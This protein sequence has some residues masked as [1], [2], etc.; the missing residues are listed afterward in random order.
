VQR[1]SLRH[2]PA[3]SLARGAVFAG[4]ALVVAA[5]TAAP[6]GAVGVPQRILAGPEDQLLASENATYVI[7]TQSSELSPNRYHAYERVRATNQVFR[8]NPRGT[9]GYAGGI[10]PDQDRA[11]YQQIDGQASDLFTIDLGTLRRIKLPVPI[12]TGRWEWG[13]R[14]S[15]S[16]FLFAR[17]APLKTTMFLYDRAA[18]TMERLVS[19]DLTKYYVAPGAVGERYATWSVCGPRTCNAFI[20]DTDTDQTK[21]IPAPDGKP[22]YAPIVDEAEGLV[23]FVRSGPTC[24][25][26]VRIMRLALADLAAAPVGLLTL[27]VGVDVGGQMSLEHVGARVDL[28]FSRYRCAPQQGD[29]YR[30]KDVGVA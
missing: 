24:G 21:K 2:F 4:L 15:N 7:W 29:I 19:L 12:N 6:A 14:I 23:Y 16:F 20:R 11:I 1:L 28:W 30:L 13:P 3:P 27:P 17:D 10:D 18:K 8:L 22:R 5:V 25:S 9:R 26:A